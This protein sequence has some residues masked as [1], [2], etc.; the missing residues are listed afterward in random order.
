LFGSFGNSSL[1]WSV[2]KRSPNA[3]NGKGG[4][5]IQVLAW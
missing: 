3:Q 2:G 5:K 4:F 1:R